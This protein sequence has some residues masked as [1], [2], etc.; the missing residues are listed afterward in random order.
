MIED[1]FKSTDSE[2]KKNRQCWLILLRRKHKS[3]NPDRAFASLIYKV[4]LVTFDKAI[5]FTNL[6][7]PFRK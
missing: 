5:E 1:E 6:N 7:C 4:L 3:K 2:N